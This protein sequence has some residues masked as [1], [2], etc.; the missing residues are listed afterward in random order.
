MENVHLLFFLSKFRVAVPAILE[1]AFFHSEPIHTCGEVENPSH[2]A[3]VQ[4]Y[5][6]CHVVLLIFTH[7]YSRTLPCAGRPGFREK[8]IIREHWLTRE[9]QHDNCLGDSRTLVNWA[10]EHLHARTAKLIREVRNSPR[11][12]QMVYSRIL[13][14]YRHSCSASVTAFV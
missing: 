8:W 13:C 14:E 12:Q 3:S 1:I 9:Y 6:L 4:A 2:V 10:C 11:H 5:T 7:E